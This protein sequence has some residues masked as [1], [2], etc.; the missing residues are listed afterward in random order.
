VGR[1]ILEVDPEQ[2]QTLVTSLLKR[3]DYDEILRPVELW[4]WPRTSERLARLRAQAEYVAKRLG[5]ELTVT[6]EHNELR[7][8]PGYLDGVWSAVAHAIRN[9]VDHG[10][11]SPAEREWLGKPRQGRISMAT[12]QTEESLVLEIGDDGAGIDWKA[13]RLRRESAG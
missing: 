6:I 2:H 12:R 7:I 4:S 10:I 3:H 5:K 1:N 13:R 8:P 11:E 9:A